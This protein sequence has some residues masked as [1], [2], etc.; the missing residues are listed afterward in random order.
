[1]HAPNMSGQGNTSLP[2]GVWSSLHAWE[3]SWTAAT[4]DADMN[5]A[6]KGLQHRTLL[7]TAGWSHHEER[8][9]L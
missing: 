2:A 5:R 3:L 7:G 8:K 4:I 1:M 9:P 6:T